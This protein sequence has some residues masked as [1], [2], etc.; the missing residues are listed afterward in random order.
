MGG[1]WGV[2]LVR[3]GSKTAI[4][5]VKDLIEIDLLMGET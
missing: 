3:N 4:Y 5:W 1:A 2:W